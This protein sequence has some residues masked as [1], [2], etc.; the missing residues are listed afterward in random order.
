MRSRRSPGDVAFVLGTRELLECLAGMV[1]GEH[2]SASGR[3]H[4]RRAIA[5]NLWNNLTGASVDARPSGRMGPP[6][7]TRTPCR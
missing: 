4:P 5:N 1:A 2:F 6:I 3:I 7:E